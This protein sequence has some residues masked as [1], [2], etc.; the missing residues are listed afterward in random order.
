MGKSTN[1]FHVQ[2][3]SVTATVV[4]LMAGIPQSAEGIW[5]T[6]G[7]LTKCDRKTRRGRSGGNCKQLRLLNLGRAVPHMNGSETRL[8]R[9]FVNSSSSESFSSFEIP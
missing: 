1:K 2:G 6:H 4:K 7:R 8:D 9:P 5:L 3:D